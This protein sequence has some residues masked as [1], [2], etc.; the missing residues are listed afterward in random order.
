MRFLWGAIV[1]MLAGCAGGGPL[2]PFIVPPSRVSQD[3]AVPTR[4]VDP[5][6][7]QNISLCYNGATTSEQSVAA[8][9]NRH[10]R[11][12][13]PVSN[14]FDLG[15]CPVALP[16]RLFVYCA[17]GISVELAQERPPTWIYRPQ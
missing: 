7:P 15:V 2:D 9:L 12:P 4:P 3:P 16:T 5:R 8:L 6:Q 14:R 17:D 13:E 11:R 10:C 1:A